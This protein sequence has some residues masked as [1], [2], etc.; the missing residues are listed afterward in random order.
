MMSENRFTVDGLNIQDNSIKG[1]L[2]LLGEQGG[3]NALCNLLNGLNNKM[4][5]LEAENE[6]LKNSCSVM[7]Q[8]LLEKEECN[9]KKA[10]I[11]FCKFMNINTP[12]LDVM[13]DEFLQ[14]VFE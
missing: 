12:L 2:Y 10:I 9:Y 14:E 3:V 8:R 5:R 1:R 7:N 6:Q 4:N 13:V 11:E